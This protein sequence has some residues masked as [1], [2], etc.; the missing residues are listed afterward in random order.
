[1]L[2]PVSGRAT[3]SGPVVSVVFLRS[4]GNMEQRTV[5][6]STSKNELA[7][8]LEGQLTLIGEFPIL[9][10]V[11]MKRKDA[12]GLK[13]SQHKLP[14]PL[15][16]EPHHGDIVLVKSARPWVFVD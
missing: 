9:R 12:A 10:T 11:A 6:M 8:M 1:M 15:N 13:R 14:F 7:R 4:N 3:L 16:Q 5:D 2:T